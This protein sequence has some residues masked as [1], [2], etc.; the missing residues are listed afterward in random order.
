Q[1]ERVIEIAKEMSQDHRDALS[2]IVTASLQKEHGT[3]DLTRAGFFDATVKINADT[4]ICLTDTGAAI[5]FNPYEVAPW[6]MGAPTVKVSAAELR[7]LM[8]ADS[9]ALLP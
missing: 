3:P 1:K 7:P 2:K 4:A 9:G 6:S 5:A 8:P